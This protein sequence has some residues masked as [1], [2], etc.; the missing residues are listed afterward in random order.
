MQ[1]SGPLIPP[2]AD[3]G[4]GRETPFSAIEIGA[5]LAQLLC[6]EQ[7]YKA[8]RMCRLL[9][10]LIDK[11]LAG[12]LR[13][14]SE[15]AIGVD[16]FDRDPAHFDTTI[17]SVVRVQAGRLR[18]RLNDYYAVHAPANGIIISIPSGSY[19]PL[20]RRQRPACADLPLALL[21][22]IAGLCC[23]SAAPAAHQFAQ[24]ME[25][26]LRYQLYQQLGN[27]IRL[28][29]RPAGAPQAEASGITHLLESSIQLDNGLLRIN[30]RL[31]EIASGRLT[32]YRRFDRHPVP[33]LS[34]QEELAACI[35]TAVADVL[36]AGQS[37]LDPDVTGSA[38][39]C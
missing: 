36:Q 23:L 28:L 18:Q 12:A 32:W 4:P 30:A 1:L 7:F 17:D 15:Y 10:Y 14:M 20:I 26:A 39:T 27:G 22:G 33:A 16:V 9:S 21:L 19:M 2:R 29:T 3:A 25:E 8:H 5:A 6:S 38:V 11:H 13:D 35:A 37:A 34:L 31:T 24:A